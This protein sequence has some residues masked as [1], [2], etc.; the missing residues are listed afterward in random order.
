MKR[1]DKEMT[2]ELLEM[3]LLNPEQQDKVAEKYINYYE[4]K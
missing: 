1:E 3:E 2:Q 4:G